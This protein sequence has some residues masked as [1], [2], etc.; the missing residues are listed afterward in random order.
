MLSAFP[1]VFEF[2]PHFLLYLAEETYSCRFGTFLLNSH[3]KRYTQ[4]IVSQTASIWGEVEQLVIAEQCDPFGVP[5]SERLVNLM[6]E[7]NA[8][9]HPWKLLPLLHSFR[10]RLWEEFYFKF[11]WYGSSDSDDASRIPDELLARIRPRGAAL[12]AA[13]FDRRPIEFSSYEPKSL[14]RIGSVDPAADEEL[15]HFSLPRSDAA[16]CEL[17]LEPFTFFFRRHTCRHCCRSACC[18]CASNFI[19]LPRHAVQLREDQGTKGPFRVCREC[20]ALW[21]GRKK[22]KS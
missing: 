12:Q 8:P 11:W 17:C 9:L 1:R 21:G 22:K 7:P 20:F 5:H 13:L 16:E 15:F 4:A 6:F 18:N 2:T 19:D 10:Y 3:R 14:E